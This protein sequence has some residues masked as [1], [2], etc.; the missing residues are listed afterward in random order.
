MVVTRPAAAGSWWRDP[1]VDY[2]GSFWFPVTREQLWATIEEFDSFEAWW[3]W[4]REFSAASRGL[5]DGNVLSGLVV[6]P[7]PYRLRLRVTLDS[8]TRPSSIEA[9]IDG[10]LRGHAALSLLPVDGGTRVGATWRLEM[11]SMPMRVAARVAYPVVRW[12]HDRVVDMTVAGFRR[13]V[14]AISRSS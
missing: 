9:T 12:G 3:S 14:V 13:R 7:V 2:D 10:D 8:C 1:I 11:A 6:P 5:V 4:L